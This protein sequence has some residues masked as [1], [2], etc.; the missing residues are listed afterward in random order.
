MINREE[1]VL[2]VIDIQ[3]K[4]FQAMYNKEDL[5]TIAAK[6]IRGAKV[7]NLPIIVTEQIP[8]KLGVTIPEIA[9]EL[10]GI[11]RISKSS[12]SSWGE[13]KFREKIKAVN[14]P[15]AV[16]IGIES[17]ICVYQ[18]AADLINNGY[19][20]HIV[21]DAVSSRTKENSDIG[22]AAIKSSGGHITSMEMFLFE[23]L[24]AAE[25]AGFKDIQKI[26]K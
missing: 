20:V 10:E 13:S 7:F 18:T 4:L 15:K 14:C 11:E 2:I 17:H 23:I 25:N 21:A 8:E 1:S 19:E 12:F 5:L 3:D 9:V 26:V 22:L 6:T 16:I 24:G